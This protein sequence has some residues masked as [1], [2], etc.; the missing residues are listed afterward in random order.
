M[1]FIFNEP[2][3]ILQKTWE[4][5]L[6][7]DL[8]AAA[9]RQ[10]QFLDNVAHEYFDGDESLKRGAKRYRKFLALM[11]DNPGVFVV[12]MYDIDL[13]WHAHILRDTERYAQET[14]NFVGRFVNHKEDDDRS[15]GGS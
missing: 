9:A 6:N 12:P 15:A 7:Y 14:R 5:P 8:K 2:H 10:K 11:R 1:E 4:S 3:R 13:V